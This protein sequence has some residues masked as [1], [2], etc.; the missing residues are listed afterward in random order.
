MAFDMA[1]GAGAAVCALLLAGCGGGGGSGGDSESGMPPRTPLAHLVQ[2]TVPPGSRIDVSADDF[3]VFVAGDR[4]RYFGSN[5]SNQSVEVVREVVTGP[6]G[7]GRVTVRQTMPSHP[8]VEALVER[9]QRRPEGLVALDYLGDGAPAGFRALVGDFLLYPTP[10]YPAGSIRTAVRQGDLGVDLDGDTHNESF[11]FEFQQEFA[12]FETGDRGGRQERRARF[13][14][15]VTVTIQPS[16][17]DV[18]VA[19]AVAREEVVFAAHLGLLSSVTSETINP[20][21]GPTT[22]GFSLISG[23]LAGRDVN[24]AWNA[25]TTRSIA[26]RHFDLA[27]EPVAGYYYAGLAA[28]DTQAPGA[29]ARIH[30]GTGVVAYSVGLG[31]DVRSIAVSADGSTLYAGLQSQAEIVQLSLPDLQVVRRIALDP[32]T[33]GYGLAVSPLDPGTFAY[34]PDNSQRGPVLVR[35]GQLQPNGP[36]RDR[37]TTQATDEPMI[38]SPDGAHV[39]LFGNGGLLQLDVLADGFGASVEAAAAMPLGRSLS[40][41]GADIVAGN[42]RYRPQDLQRLAVVQDGNLT[43]CRAM[44]GVAKWFCAPPSNGPFAVAVVDSNT[45]R[46]LPDGIVPV[47]RPWGWQSGSV[48]RV[49]PGPA[50]Q[51]ALMIGSSFYGDWLALFDNNDFR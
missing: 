29:V 36:G 23:T 11:R 39:F 21:A 33:Y 26:M 25:G 30:P 6:D 3:F 19:T 34:Y 41:Q 47:A 43:G 16:R 24:T 18:A 27:Y 9:W 17:R 15:T 5:T 40:R 2:D 14:N 13:R 1:R 48:L 7:G 35:G 32:G 28:S 8:A 4:A 37:A 12:G 31:A 44:V 20:N 46:T 50:G 45:M 10:F 51:V 42:G 49:V 38:F 22:L